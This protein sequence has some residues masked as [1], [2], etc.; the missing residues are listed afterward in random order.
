V[1]LNNDIG[2]ILAVSGQCVSEHPIVI[3]DALEPRLVAVEVD[4]RV[5]VSPA[6][7]RSRGRCSTDVKVEG[8][9]PTPP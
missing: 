9:T 5:V 4:E 6:M 7:T 8:Q 3:V 2:E 1:T